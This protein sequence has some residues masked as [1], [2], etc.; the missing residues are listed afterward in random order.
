MQ[1][2]REIEMKNL[3]VCL[4]LVATSM[5]VLGCQTER[6]EEE[7]TYS[8]V[9][10]LLKEA[11]ECA[12]KSGDTQRKNRAYS[13][14]SEYRGSYASFR[15]DKVVK[16]DATEL[17]REVGIFLASC[18]PVAQAEEKQKK[19]KEAQQR[20]LKDLRDADHKLGVCKRELGTYKNLLWATQFWCEQEERILC[21]VMPSLE[22]RF[23]RD[24]PYWSNYIRPAGVGKMVSK[25]TGTHHWLAVV[26]DHRLVVHFRPPIPSDD[27][28][29]TDRFMENTPGVF[30]T[31]ETKK[32]PIFALYLEY[33]KDAKFTIG[34][35]TSVFAPFGDSTFTKDEILKFIAKHLT[36]TKGVKSAQAGRVISMSDWIDRPKKATD[37]ML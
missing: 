11:V 36:K 25:K 2:E 37:P 28:G 10:N 5:S 29:W 27:G 20:D 8:V 6:E 4:V 22:E 13:L 32:D 12:D 23:V 35:K 30:N 16:K 9:D 24:F 1:R 31:Y 3:F 33:E 17:K 15:R 26:R 14:I 7:V 19:D 18:W 21:E 34:K